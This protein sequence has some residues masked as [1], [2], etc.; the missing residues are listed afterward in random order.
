[1]AASTVLITVLGTAVT[2][3]LVERRLGRYQGEPAPMQHLG[4]A[5]KRGLWAAVAAAGALAVVL[6]LLTVPQGGPLRDPQTGSL[7]H[8]PFLSGIVAIIFVAFF[9]PGL[10]YG[11]ATGS[12]RSDADVVRMM[13]T[14]M[15]GLGSY[16]VLVFAAAQFVALFSWTHVGV[17][18]AIKGAEM[19]RAVGMTGIPLVVSFIFVSAALNLLMGSASAKWAI[20]APVFV[21]MFMLLGYTPELT[22]AAYRIGDSSTNVITPMMSYF[23]LILTF[24]QKYRK[25]AGIGTVVALM[26]PY[27]A[28]F[29]LAWSAFLIGWMMLGLPLGPGAGLRL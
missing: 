18:T 22:Q 4:P 24:V 27:S 29:V 28:V 13:G 15:S 23:A 5:E 3:R 25:D 21:P 26:L 9:T 12:I 8:S 2:E 1:M 10:A 14:T 19:L 7:L 11:I 20:M 6:L 17:I 16:I